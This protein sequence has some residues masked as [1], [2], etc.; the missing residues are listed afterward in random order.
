MSTYFFHFLSYCLWVLFLSL[1]LIDFL[2]ISISQP[3]VQYLS[4]L[5]SDC[6][7]VCL[8]ACLPLWLCLVLSFIFTLQCFYWCLFLP[9]CQTLFLSISNLLH[10]IFIHLTC[11]P[12]KS[13]IT[14]RAKNSRPS[15]RLE[16]KPAFRFPW[17]LLR[18]DMFGHF[19]SPLLQLLSGY[20]R[21]DIFSSANFMLMKL[22]YP[23]RHSSSIFLNV[24]WLV[25]TLLRGTWSRIP[26]D[27]FVKE[28]IQ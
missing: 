12:R 13:A 7:S 8:P 26:D 23:W 18:S 4:C 16:N 5:K 11:K 14:R 21:L 25:N 17:R 2:F 1:S 28:K 9:L 15:I 22:F 27:F 24:T 20:A 19:Q 10:Y 6:P 3:M